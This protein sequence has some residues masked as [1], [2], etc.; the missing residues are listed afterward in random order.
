MSSY[1]AEKGLELVHAHLCGHITPK[2]FGGAS[3]FLLVVDDYSRYMWVELL[4]SKDQALEC[5]KKIKNRVEVECD[6]KLKALRT[7]KGGGRVCVQSVLT[8]TPYTP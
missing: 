1:R 8:T 5:F 3:Y 6:G 2:S 7:D 4:K